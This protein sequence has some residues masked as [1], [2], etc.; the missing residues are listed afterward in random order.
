[1]LYIIKKDYFLAHYIIDAL[2]SRSDIRVIDYVRCKP[3]GLRR[4]VQKVVKFLRAFP[5]N[6]RGVWTGWM[7]PRH[8]LQAL[9]EIGPDDRVLLW[10][11]ENLK[12]LLVLR[13]ELPCPQVSAFL[14]NPVVTICRTRY[15]RWEYGHFLRK[16]DMDVCTFDEGDARTYGFRP[17]PQVYRHPD[18]S[19]MPSDE[20]RA[21]GADIVFFGQ[22]KHRSSL[23]ADIVRQCD[24]EGISHDFHILRDRHTTPHPTLAACYRDE[25][26]PY[27]DSLAKVARA[28][29]ILEVVQQGQQGMTLRTLEAVF[30]GKKLI[31]NNAAIEATPVYRKSNVYVLGREGGR[32][33]RDFLHEPIEPLPEEVVHRH[34]VRSWIDQFTH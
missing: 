13:R 24:E 6:R 15:S 14:W 7:F 28:K 23:L 2:A 32:S 20:E 29:A 12:E 10:G 26:L 8:F 21:D 33:L 19:L 31:T 4:V 17:V 5:L 18:A 25:A 3:R 34:D 9:G 16:A 11:C 30:L 27:R 1:M 22:D